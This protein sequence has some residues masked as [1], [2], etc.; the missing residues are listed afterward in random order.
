MRKASEQ[1]PGALISRPVLA[2]GLACLQGQTWATSNLSISTSGAEQGQCQDGVGAHLRL[3]QLEADALRHLSGQIPRRDQG[4]AAS[5]E[6]RMLPRDPKWTCSA[7]RP[8]M[9]S[10]VSPRVLLALKIWARF[11][12]IL[13]RCTKQVD[14][15]VCNSLGPSPS[16]RFTTLVD[17]PIISN[18]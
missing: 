6:C 1:F 13:C 11:L 2:R 14:I 18:R 12:S 8:M 3:R 15:P 7:S 5:A 4:T 10:C 17:L 16:S 9:G